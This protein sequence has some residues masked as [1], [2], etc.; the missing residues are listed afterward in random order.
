MTK[1]APPFVSLYLFVKSRLHYINT[2][3]GSIEDCVKCPL[4]MIECLGLDTEV[5]RDWPADGDT[6]NAVLR[7]SSTSSQAQFSASQRLACPLG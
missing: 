2:P 6:D 4:L 7:F 1:A 3:G 5:L